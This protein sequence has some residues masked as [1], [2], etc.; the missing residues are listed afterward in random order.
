[1]ITPAHYLPRLLICAVLLFPAPSVA[2]AQPVTATCTPPTPASDAVAGNWLATT[3]Q[4]CASKADT[5]VGSACAIVAEFEKTAFAPKT[6]PLAVFDAIEAQ[7]RSVETG[8]TT[9]AGLVK[10]HVAVLRQRISGV[11]QDLAALEPVEIL[12]GQ[13]A[14]PRAGPISPAVTGSRL[15]PDT[16]NSDELV[17]FRGEKAEIDLE[18]YLATCGTA[19][20]RELAAANEILRLIAL[21]R[22]TLTHVAMAWHKGLVTHVNAIVGQWDQFVAIN[23]GQ[24]PWELLLNGRLYGRNRE[25]RSPPSSQWILVHPEPAA[26]FRVSSDRRMTPTVAISLI[27]IRRWRWQDVSDQTAIDEKSSRA[28]S[29]W[30]VSALAVVGAEGF[31]K[32][33]WGANVY[34]SRGIWIGYAVGKVQSDHQHFIVVS[35][36][37]MRV[38]G[39]AERVL[40]TFRGAIR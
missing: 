6:P 14:N 20:D 29:Q 11:R 25:F 39:S 32:I 1:M 2:L 15:T 3:G 31:P 19:C 37:V 9:Q 27:G 8:A 36:D 7:A 26:W 23:K 28:R 4:R 33:A 40:G 22:R 5:C 21:T 34:A 35:G 10:Q 16:W 38:V 18:A 24:T 13:L 12:D 30:G 17:F